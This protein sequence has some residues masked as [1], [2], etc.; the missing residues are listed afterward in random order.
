MYCIWVICLQRKGSTTLSLCSVVTLLQSLTLRFKKMPNEIP[1]LA[2]Y[3]RRWLYL[4]PRLS[5]PTWPRMSFY[6]ISSDSNHLHPASP[7]F[8]SSFSPPH[9][10]F[11]LFIQTTKHRNETD[12]SE[13]HYA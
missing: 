1:E 8:L 13:W 12:P 10:S 11:V 5:G 7:P 9:M 2:L 3:L 6:I 4:L